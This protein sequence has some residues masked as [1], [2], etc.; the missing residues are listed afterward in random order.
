M[1]VVPAVGASASVGEV[2]QT[3]AGTVPTICAGK[4]L[5]NMGGQ[6]GLGLPDLGSLGVAGG[7]LDRGTMQ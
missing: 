7:I 6:A 1:V 2:S 4:G 5:P 3:L